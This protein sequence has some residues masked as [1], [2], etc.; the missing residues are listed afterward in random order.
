MRLT[1]VGLLLLPAASDALRAPLAPRTPT[2]FAAAPLD[3][4]RAPHPVAL[5]GSY[6]V[7][8]PKPLGIC[9]EEMS[10]GKPEGVVVANLVEG[11]NADL[12]G[13]ILV[14]D[15]LIRA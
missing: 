7:R 13:R 4:H 10:V 15:R 2:R 1:A 3:V 11:G 14:G 6:T 5:V 9:F 8:L 12:D